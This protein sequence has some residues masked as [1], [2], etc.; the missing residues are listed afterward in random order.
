MS[1]NYALTG[2]CA[3]GA[4]DS[5]I[6][7]DPQFSF[8]KDSYQKHTKFHT[9]YT[10]EDIKR[11]LVVARNCD[12]VDNFYISFNIGY[13]MSDIDILNKIESFSIEIGGQYMIHH[14]KESLYTSLIIKNQTI[15]VLPVYNEHGSIH[16]NVRIPIPT[17]KCSIPLI[18]LEY[19]DVKVIINTEKIKY[20][21]YECIKQIEG[22]NTKLIDKFEGL[23]I[24]LAIKIS[25]LVLQ[26]QKLY[27]IDV[28]FKLSYRQTFLDTKERKEFAREG[29]LNL[30]ENYQTV[31]FETNGQVE[32]TNRLNFNHPVK[33]IMIIV[34]KDIPLHGRHEA[35]M[36]LNHKIDP[37]IGLEMIMNG[38]S[39]EFYDPN[40]LRISNPKMLLGK[41]L[42]TGM[43]LISYA[44]KPQ[45]HNPSGSVNMSRIDNLSIKIKFPDI[46]NAKGVSP[47][48]YVT[49]IGCN[50]NVLRVMTGMA[51]LAYAQ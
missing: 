38:S 22:N 48:Y 33:Y 36:N 4:Q 12:L 28:P 18:S 16:Y 39:G 23:P 11:S 6:S 17:F 9:Q 10:E 45:D 21:P 44:L 5:Y 2:L 49:V 41:E 42:P 3:N 34:S 19:H 24:D 46:K 27:E 30:I 15:S 1:G 47:N 8:F 37:I 31:N 32:V 40:F 25:K 50:Y 51:G 26:F 14:T 20:V 35:P 43:Y 29:R 7:D 13:K